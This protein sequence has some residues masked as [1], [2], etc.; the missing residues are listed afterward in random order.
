MILLHR[1]NLLQLIISNHISLETRVF[2]IHRAEDRDRMA[3]VPIK[4]IKEHTV[5]RRLVRWKRSID[6][7]RKALARHQ[8]AHLE[9]AY[10]D[11]F[12]SDLTIEQRRKELND[13]LEFLG[14]EITAE[15]IDQDQID[16][17]LDP[18]RSKV[19]SADTYRL[20]PGIERIERLFR[21]RE[22]GWLFRPMDR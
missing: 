4:P 19:N 3:Q 5:A 9:L 6:D 10:E 1:R 16:M 20:V 17:L 13:V 21:S 11:L 7:Y 2:A 8:I 14:R 18:A 22:N 15:G 12:G